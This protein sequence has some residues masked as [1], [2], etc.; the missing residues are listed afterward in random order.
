MKRLLMAAI[1]AAALASHPGV[2]DAG[3]RTVTGVGIGAASGLLVAGPPGAVVGA[4]IGG[5]V[6]GPRVT[7][8]PQRWCWTNW[9]GRHCRYR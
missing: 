3:E 6:G 7:P 8:G 5:I 2:A 9:R 1:S 4:V